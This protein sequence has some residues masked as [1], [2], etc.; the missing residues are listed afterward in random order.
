MGGAVNRVPRTPAE[1][2]ALLVQLAAHSGS[3]MMIPGAWE[4]RAV[5]PPAL[6]DVPGVDPH[7]ALAAQASGVSGRERLERE[8]EG[9]GALRERARGDRAS[10]LMRLWRSAL[11]PTAIAVIWSRAAPQ[12]L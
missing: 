9:G 12:P 5:S 2:T 3:P 11:H 1:S 7:L 4:A 8:L 6:H 10:F